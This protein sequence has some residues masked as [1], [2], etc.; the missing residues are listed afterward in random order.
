[1]S[2]V[3]HTDSIYVVE[4][5]LIV[6]RSQNA[7]VDVVQLLATTHD[8]IRLHYFEDCTVTKIFIVHR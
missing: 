2:D 7:V 3:Y 8:Y 1:M 4:F 6:L 5:L